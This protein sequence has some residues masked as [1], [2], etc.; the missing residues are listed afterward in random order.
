[1]KEDH[2]FFKALSGIYIANVAI[3]ALLLGLQGSIVKNV[4]SLEPP[5]VRSLQ[6][7]ERDPLGVSLTPASVPSVKTQQPP[8]NGGVSELSQKVDAL[9]RDLNQDYVIDERIVGMSVAGLVITSLFV[10]ISLVAIGLQSKYKLD[11][12]SFSKQM[13]TPKGASA[14][15][16]YF[17]IFP[18]MT[19]L[20]LNTLL[21]LSGIMIGV[22]IDKK[23]RIYRPAQDMMIS[24]VSLTAFYVIF[25]DQIGKTLFRQEILDEV[26]KTY[27]SSRRHLQWVPEL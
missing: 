13:E 26:E 2:D 10:V 14:Q 22:T 5:S 17:K 23:S 3:G 20:L 1:M 4:Q 16:A 11:K 9:I 12:E 24:L 27:P 7:R 6:G 18:G 25:V 8:E 21:L 15:R 19:L